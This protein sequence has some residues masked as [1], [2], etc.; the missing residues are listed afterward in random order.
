MVLILVSVL[1]F[2]VQSLPQYHTAQSEAVSLDN[3]WF[4]FDTIVIAVFTVD[5]IVRIFSSRHIVKEVSEID[6]LIDLITILPFYIA[7]IMN[8]NTRVATLSAIRVVR[9]LRVFRLLKF[10]AYHRGLDVLKSTLNKAGGVLS[11]IAFLA[12]I[13]CVFF[14]SLL[15]YVEVSSCTFDDDLELW[16]YDDGQADPRDDGTIA[17]FQSIPDSLLYVLE[18]MS[19]GPTGSSYPRSAVGKMLAAAII[20]FGIVLVIALPVSV[21]LVSMTRAVREM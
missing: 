15:Y 5:Y 21:I 1:V 17:A 4:L 11:I 19:T 10:A 12:V 6:A 18:T 8:N 13:A 20:I 14:G 3:T 7:L 9:L 2:S 16:V